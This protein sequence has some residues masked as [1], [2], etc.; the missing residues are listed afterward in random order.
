M[1]II[2]YDAIPKRTQL[3]SGFVE[4]EVERA[5]TR[6]YEGR[7]T[8]NLALRV[9]APSDFNGTVTEGNLLYHTFYLGTEEDPD[10]ELPET[11]ASQRG[12]G[13][14]VRFFDS[15]NLP[16]EPDLERQLHAAIGNHGVV[17]QEL[18]PSRNDPNKQYN[19]VK[20]WFRLGE[21]QPG[22]DIVSNGVVA[23]SPAQRSASA[24]TPRKPV[25]MTPT[26]GRVGNGKP[27]QNDDDNPF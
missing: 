3:P 1:P 9:L 8:V 18:V 6:D 15:L 10:G 19:N 26:R 5:E 17:R 22:W 23:K 12:W 11:Q 25:G 24:P 13:D 16:Q 14:L 4:Y 27:K 7:L 21:R 20:G 2:L